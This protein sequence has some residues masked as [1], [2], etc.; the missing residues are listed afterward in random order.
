MQARLLAVRALEKDL[1]PPL[2]FARVLTIKDGGLLVHGKEMHFRG[3]KS[4]PVDRLQTWW[5]ITELELGLAA[6]ARMNPR[7]SCG[8]HVNDD[9]IT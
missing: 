5:C 4:K 8:F 3:L 6:L 1:L 7:S 9:E 2:Q